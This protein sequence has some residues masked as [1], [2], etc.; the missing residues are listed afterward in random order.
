MDTIEEAVR[1]SDIVA[2]SQHLSTLPTGNPEEYPY[3][4]EEVDQ[5]GSRDQ[6]HGGA[7]DFDDDFIMNPRE[8]R[9]GQYQAL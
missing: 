4:A 6:F 2:A 3:I 7:S 5:A 8:D 9:G 1:D